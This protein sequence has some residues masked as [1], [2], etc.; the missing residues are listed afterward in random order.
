MWFEGVLVAIHD[1]MTFQV[2]PRQRCDSG[3][4][5]DRTVGRGECGRASTSSAQMPALERPAMKPNLSR[6]VQHSQFSVR[7]PAANTSEAIGGWG[8]PS[9]IA[10]AV[11][12]PAKR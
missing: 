7:C 10:P 6:T 9:R 5:W 4:P 2:S 12:C 1:E 11:P 8:R 3:I